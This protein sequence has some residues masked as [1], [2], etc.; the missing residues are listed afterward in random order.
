[1]RRTR[2]LSSALAVLTL[3]AAAPSALAAADPAVVRT[4]D[5]PVRGTVTQQHRLFQG[6]PFAAPPT[7]ERRWQPPAPVTPWTEVRDATKAGSACP[8]RPIFPVGGSETG[9]EDCL[10]LNVSTPS[11][12]SHKPRPVMVWIHGGGFVGGAGADYPATQLAARGDVVVVTVNYRLGAL[13]FLSLPGLPGGGTF[14]LQDQQAALR[15]VQANARAFGGDPRN[16]TVFGESAGAL[17]VCAQLTSPAARGLF[18]RAITQSGPC[19]LSWRDS[20]FLPDVP[21]GSNWTPLA[22]ADKTGTALATTLGCTGDALACL[23]TAPV[24]KLLDSAISQPAFDTPLL[25]THPA[26]AVE[27]GRFARVPVLT[28]ITRDEH[29]TFTAF[30]PEPLT[31][32]KYAALLRTTYGDKADQV[33]AKYPISAYSSPTIAW[34]TT[35]TDAVWARTQLTT[36]RQLA[37]RVPTFAYEF[38]DR[39]VPSVIPSV[40]DMGAYHG[41]ELPYLFPGSL[42]V[43]LNPAQQ[44]LGERMQRYW[45]NFARTGQPNGPGLPLWLPSGRVENTVQG[46]DI[47]PAGIGRVD[48]AAEHNYAFWTAI[49]G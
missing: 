27:A 19:E 22:D 28:G 45:V 7:G 4:T 6:I 3:L 35:V 2:V 33:L 25:P 31:A 15:W 20:G 10:S 16:V 43:T 26:K 1:M 23:R 40:P 11:A 41:S 42:P 32:E 8:Q 34:A 13:G 38:R 49:L 5:G 46:L 36:T 48:T 47:A 21:A 39:T 37:R 44:A 9:S 12:P 30:I 24:S 17:S 18:H 14:G 29:R